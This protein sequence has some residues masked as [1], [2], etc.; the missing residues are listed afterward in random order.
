MEVLMMRERI[1]GQRN[2]QLVY[3]LKHFGRIYA[4]QKWY[5]KS[6]HALNISE[7]DDNEDDILLVLAGIFFEI[8]NHEECFP[9]QVLHNVML[10]ASKAL[11]RVISQAKI[12]KNLPTMLYLVVIAS[13]VLNQIKDDVIVQK[14]FDS[15]I[16]TFNR[17]N[18][19]T[20]NGDTLVHLAINAHTKMDNHNVILYYKF[21]S[22]SAVQLLTDCGGLNVNV[23]NVNRNIPLHLIA[24]YYRSI[25]PNKDIL[26][27]KGIMQKPNEANCH[28][29][30]ANRYNQIPLQCTRLRTIELFI[31]DVMKFSLK[32]LVARHIRN[33]KLKRYEYLSERLCD[34]MIFTHAGYF[35]KK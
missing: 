15:L 35:Q 33:P 24:S 21:P 22:L 9:F 20:S 5:T 6:S 2:P 19:H 12:D 4:K 31:K 29:D 14:Q 27:I 18:I 13:Q 32:C 28:W 11:K 1:L 16:Y 17:M 8:I 23:L 34:F 7:H 30:I 10:S 26:I 25:V 3:P